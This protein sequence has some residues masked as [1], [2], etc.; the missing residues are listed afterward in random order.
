[1]NDE[2][3]NASQNNWLASSQKCPSSTPIHTQLCQ[4]SSLAR[5]Y[6]TRDPPPASPPPPPPPP[7][8]HP[9]AVFWR[10]HRPCPRCPLIRVETSNHRA[11]GAALVAPTQARGRPKHPPEAG[12]KNARHKKS[13]S[14]TDNGDIL[15]SFS[16][17]CR[18]RFQ[19]ARTGAQRSVEHG[20]SQQV[21]G[22]ELVR[23]RPPRAAPAVTPETAKSP[24]ERAPHI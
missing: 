12:E 19:K 4:H 14:R 18:G 21:Q 17:S 7:P 5:N 10:P 23:Q 9:R 20:H 6:C 24:R 15:C 11:D 22:E 3:S 2:R 13:L 1:M 16:Q 8:P